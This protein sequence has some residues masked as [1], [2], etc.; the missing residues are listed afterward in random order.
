M[1][2]TAILTLAIA[3]PL[4]HAADL[5]IHV[6]N[7]KSGTGQVLV[8]LYDNADAFLKRPARATKVRADKT[9]TTLV[10][11]DVAPGDYGFSVFHDVNDNGRMDTNPIGIPTEPTAFS[12]NAR[13]RMGPPA[14][15]AAKLAV[16]AAGLDTTVSLR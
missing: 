8:A 7:V 15:D 5:V 13:G 9:G 6:D 14:F 16:P 11:H 2:R 10:F 3:A 1:I 12:N 4:A